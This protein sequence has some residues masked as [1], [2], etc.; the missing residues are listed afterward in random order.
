M[1]VRYAPDTLRLLQPHEQVRSQGKALAIIFKRKIKAFP[2]MIPGP[3]E[4][5]AFK[6]NRLITSDEIQ[7]PLFGDFHLLWAIESWK[8]AP[9]DASS[10]PTDYINS[11]FIREGDLEDFLLRR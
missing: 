8:F 1:N 2:K 9:G 6:H 3:S 11:G 4:L 7:P 10:G 5:F